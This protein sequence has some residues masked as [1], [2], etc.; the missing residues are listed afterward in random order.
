M[1]K[2]GGDAESTSTQGGITGCRLL[3][4]S[5]PIGRN[6][7]RVLTGHE[8]NDDVQIP[9]QQ[10]RCAAAA[11]ASIAQLYRLQHHPEPWQYTR[12]TANL[13]NTNQLDARCLSPSRSEASISATEAPGFDIILS[14][15]FVLSIIKS[16]TDRSFNSSVYTAS[17]AV[18]FCLLWLAPPAAPAR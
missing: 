12:G 13:P 8:D 17:F 16:R 7:F 15:P 5:R 4:F 6:S 2:E 1:K 10:I 11:P 14:L 3:A 18:H 9:A